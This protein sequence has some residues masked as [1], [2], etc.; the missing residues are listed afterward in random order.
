MTSNLTLNVIELGFF[1]LKIEFNPEMKS[2]ARIVSDMRCPD[3]AR[4]DAA[5]D[6]IESMV[7]A[8]F[9]AGVDITSS[10]YLEG[11]E[12]ACSAIS[13][14]YEDCDEVAQFQMR[15]WRLS[16]GYSPED[17][18]PQDLCTYTMKIS[19]SSTTGA[20]YFSL[21]NAE[22]DGNNNLRQLIYPT[23][24]H[25]VIE[26]RDGLPA[27]SVGVTP[28]T[29]DIHVISN[30]SNKLAIIKEQDSTPHEWRP[31]EFIA[32]RHVGMVLEVDDDESLNEARTTMAEITFATYD[33]GERI[34]KES[35]GWAVDGSTWKKTVFFEDYSDGDS[36]KRELTVNF[37]EDSAYI[38]K[39]SIE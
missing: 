17:L 7:L 19:R 2:A 27:M 3:N 11:I 37:K 12:T 15:D 34:V 24:L 30:T 5:V 18:P 21:F 6:A 4:Q 36:M 10:S 1:G 20:I 29:N 35:S 16:E 14:R 8:H 25:G 28:D 9:C 33:F 26:V 39:A 22:F 38:Y 31:V 23:G 13:D 32:A